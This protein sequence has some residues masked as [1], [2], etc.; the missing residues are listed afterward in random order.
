MYPFMSKVLIKLDVIHRQ[1][2]LPRG[3]SLTSEFVCVLP[4]SDD[5]AR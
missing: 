5:D 4:F 3:V 2:F 1:Q